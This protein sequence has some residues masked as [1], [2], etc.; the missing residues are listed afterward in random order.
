MKNANR[1]SS[2]RE[3][4]L[5]LLRSTNA[6]PT[7]EWLYAELKKNYPR[8]G[9]ATVYRNLRLFQEQGLIQ[10]VDVGDGPDHFDADTSQ[11][12]HYCCTCCGRII[13]LDM[14]ELEINSSLPCGLV[15]QRHQ[16][17][18]FGVCSSCKKEQCS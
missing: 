15:A 1:H 14:P 16:L 18:F 2:Q 12:Y 4:I 3:A 10:R 5:V 11:H 13:D 9:L 17:T 7:A 8:I 6:H